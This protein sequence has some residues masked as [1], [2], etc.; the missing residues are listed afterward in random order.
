MP[1]RDKSPSSHSQNRQMSAVGF[2]AGRG[3][4]IVAM[5]LA[6]LIG[7]WM[8]WQAKALWLWFKNKREQYA[9]KSP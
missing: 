5:F 2:F 7:T 6:G 3:D 8:G 4:V 9:S 1:K